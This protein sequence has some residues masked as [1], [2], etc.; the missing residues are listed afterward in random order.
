ML[1]HYHAVARSNLERFGVDNGFRDLQILVGTGPANWRGTVTEEVREHV[2][3]LLAS[4]MSPL[5]A[6]AVFWW[7]RNQLYLDQDLAHD[8]RIRVMRY[9]AMMEKAHE[10][11][12][13]LSD[14]VGLRLPLAAMERQIRPIRQESG[15]LRPDIEMLCCNLLEKFQ[16]VPDLTRH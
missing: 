6:A 16:N 12:E 1:R 5:D 10:C 11:L 9:E 3:K 8:D 15:E 13:A 4:G 14:F 7:T 2:A